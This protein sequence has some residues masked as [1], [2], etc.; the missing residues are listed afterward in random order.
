MVNGRIAVMISEIFD[1]LDYEL[2]NGIY[3]KASSLGYDTICLT[4]IRDV[5]LSTNNKIVSDKMDNVY[6]LIRSARFDGIIFIAESFY[7]EHT[8]R[9]I[10][11]MLRQTSVPCVVIGRVQDGFYTAPSDQRSVIRQL[12]EHLIYQH[13]C[14]H[15]AFVSGFKGESNSEERYAG[16]L[17]ALSDAGLVFCEENDLYFGEYWK[18]PSEQIGRKIAADKE[19]LPDAVVCAS[20]LMAVYL[21]EGLISSGVRVPEDVKITGYDGEW[22]A[23]LHTPSITTASGCKY[24]EGQRAVSELYH[25]MTGLVAP[26]NETASKLCCGTSCGCKPDMKYSSRTVTNKNWIERELLNIIDKHLT[27][28]RYLN[29]DISDHVSRADTFESLIQRIHDSA[30]ALQGWYRISICLCSDWRFDFERPEVYRREGFS[31]TMQLVMDHNRYEPDEIS[32]NF[33]I[34]HLL[35]MLE[36]EHSPVLVTISA[37][38]SGEQ[39]LGY[40]AFYYDDVDSINYDAQFMNWN[41]TAVSGFRMIQQKL[42]LEYKQRKNIAFSTLDPT[43]GFYNQRGFLEL[44]SARG[45]SECV[46]WMFGIYEDND[47]LTAQNEH[48]FFSTA[49]RLSSDKNEDIAVLGD[50]LFAVVFKKSD[51]SLESCSFRRLLRCMREAERLQPF[52]RYSRSPYVLSVSFLLEGTAEQKQQKAAELAENARQRLCSGDHDTLKSEL[53]W[54]R[55]R[56]WL[57]PETDLSIDDMARQ[58]NISQ[59]YLHRIYKNRFGISAKEDVICAR[60]EKAKQLLLSSGASVNEI[61]E[62]CGYHEASH[63]MRQFRDRVGITATGYRKKGRSE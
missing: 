5:R 24:D 38:N 19:S 50:H 40:T 6:N 52:D 11:S 41:S 8:E 18:Q 7:S 60:I 53:L 33:P 39:I 54:L 59:T 26:E 47:M 14:R 58:L 10:F 30:E 23:V 34:T 21:S 55:I 12:T 32:Q 31:D 25:C 48:H 3:T 62:Q 37:L 42:Y 63:F 22:Y 45:E 29:N 20:D 44:L 4:G 1:P 61:A 51:V 17:E 43:T 49:L 57:H 13:G 28:G 9:S 56:I 16:F 35:P 36:Q 27:S 2:L 46:L 15:F